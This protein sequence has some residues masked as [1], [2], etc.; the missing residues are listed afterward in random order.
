[1]PTWESSNSMT[2]SPASRALGKHEMQPPF[3]LVFVDMIPK[4][5]HAQAPNPEAP[6]VFPAP[7]SQIFPCCHH[8]KSVLQKALPVSVHSDGEVSS[9]FWLLQS[10]CFGVLLQAE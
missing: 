9:A 1:M 10:S 8:Y 5:L 6:F 7:L 3:H 2:T 4:P